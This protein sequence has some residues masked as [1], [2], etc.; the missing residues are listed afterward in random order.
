MEAS[1]RTVS[2]AVA[3]TLL[4]SK[5]MKAFEY[6]F[7]IMD[8]YSARCCDYAVCNAKLPKR[9]GD[10]AMFAGAECMILHL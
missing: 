7:K 3:W 2:F 9:N 6:F 5:Q 10:E 4:Q 1:C 8:A